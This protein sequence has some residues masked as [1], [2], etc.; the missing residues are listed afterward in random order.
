MFAS[1]LRTGTSATRLSQLTRQFTTTSR[2]AYNGTQST[3]N[4]GAKIPAIGFGTWQDKNAQ[5]PAVAK[6]LKAGYR[7]IDTARIYGTEPAVGN[8]IKKSGI[9]R[10]DIF[11]TT[12]LWNNS[13]HP[14]D[15]EKALDA[16]L[17]DLGTDY[18]DLYLMHWPSPFARSDDMF[19]KDSAG[20]I[21]P[22]SSDYV[23]TYKAMEKCF[24][25]GKARAIG[26]SNFSRAELERLLSST[27][28]VPAAH[29]IE[30]H[31]YLQQRG[32]T[33][34]HAE[35]NIH[36]T[37]YSPF[38]NQNAIYDAGAGMGK[39]MDDPVL[40]EIGKK[41]GKSGAQVALAWGIAQGHSVIPKSKTPSRIAHNLEG[42]FRLPQEDLERIA[43]IDK[44]MRFN[45]PS[46]NFG[47]AFYQDLD[48]KKK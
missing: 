9:A 33:Q 18:V 28:V 25:S 36:V 47:W 8:A 15:V 37:Q 29:Q 27:S 35:H 31:P 5:E 38:G 2:L 26:I 30:C 32:F 1:S 41:H 12:K 24:Q 3:L 11:L 7:H 40:V 21:K 42:D 19:P 48:G 43:G 46:D 20:K 14:D 4:T 17:K 10:E 23:D 6:A 13:H 34:W 22:G 16:S 45:D 44:K 39:L